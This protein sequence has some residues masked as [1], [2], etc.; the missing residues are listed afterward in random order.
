[1]TRQ[2]SNGKRYGNATQLSNLVSKVGDRSFRRRGFVHS[3]IV[4]DWDHIVGPSLASV[5]APEGLRFAPGKKRGGSLTIRCDGGAALE[6]EYHKELVLE[7]VNMFFGYGA[8]ERIAIRQGPVAPRKALTKQ[9]PPQKPLT[10]EQTNHL[11]TELK[12]VRDQALKDALQRLGQSV[13]T[14]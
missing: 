2:S 9:R 14:S 7:R 1:M 13:I 3:Q 11:N 12:D 5:T 8:V 6:L 10:K 4:T